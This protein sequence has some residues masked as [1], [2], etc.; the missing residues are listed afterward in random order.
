M[1][2]DFAVIGDATLDVIVSPD[3]ALRHAGDVTATIEVGPGGQGANVAVR[4]A[5]AGADVTLVAPIGPDA[6]G[7]LLEEALTA[8]GVHVVSVPAPRSAVVVA[9]L[10]AAG[11]RSMLS[12]R[13]RLMAAAVPA[14]VD[15]A[16]W[17]HVS[18][19]A[20]L[21]DQEGDGLAAVLGAR[22]PGVRLSVAGGS[23][24][25][26]AAP[27]AGLR[28]R[29]ATARPD[30]LVASRDEAGPLLGSASPSAVEAVR[31]LAGVA[32]VVVVT[33]GQDGSAACAGGDLIEV[34]AFE[35]DA[36][37][38]DATGSGDAYLAG[39]IRSF[40]RDRWPPDTSELRM[41]MIVGGEA[42][43]RAA[44][45]LGAQARIAGE[46]PAGVGT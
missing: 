29:L 5:R 39:L 46:Q 1:V 10:D 9:L 36:P 42:G 28:G 2:T 25:P 27:V 6:A 24:P 18:G 8:E 19:Y 38:L 35:P 12:D 45:V 37:V 20:L 17:I 34:P 3:Q 41:A 21:D 26:E 30:L 11:E 15:D 7:R 4:L 23:V 14:T 33:A 32:T 43:S 40:P 22:R 31:G 44:R 13:Q 16:R